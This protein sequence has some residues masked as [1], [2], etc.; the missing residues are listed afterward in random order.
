M[1]DDM[2]CDTTDIKILLNG[3]DVKAARTPMYE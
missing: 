2:P 3:K 1:V